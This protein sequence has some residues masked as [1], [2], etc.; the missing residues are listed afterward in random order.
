M[1][2]SNVIGVN[3][4]R[5]LNIDL[6]MFDAFFSLIRV[7][8]QLSPETKVVDLLFLYNF[9]FGQISSFYIKV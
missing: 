3:R 9:Y 2:L 5:V 7:S 4:V 8:N 6:T 1:D